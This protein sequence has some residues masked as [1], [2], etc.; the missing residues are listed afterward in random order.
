M[1]KG[2]YLV[3][4]MVSAV[5]MFLFNGIQDGE[6]ALAAVTSAVTSG[7]MLTAAFAWMTATEI[8]HNAT[9]DPQET[10]R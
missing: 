1:S 7:I 8:Y 3:S 2:S 5:T 10:D 4:V 9:N 6:W